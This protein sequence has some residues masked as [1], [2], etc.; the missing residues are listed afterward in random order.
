M[1]GHSHCKNKFTKGKGKVTMQEGDKEIEKL[2]HLA[3]RDNSDMCLLLSAWRK[4][5]QQT[6]VNFSVVSKHLSGE[7]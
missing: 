3:L 1:L 5:F 6:S 7:A 2:V 4:S